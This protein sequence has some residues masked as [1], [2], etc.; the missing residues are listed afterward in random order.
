MRDVIL[1]ARWDIYTENHED[2]GSDSRQLGPALVATV[3]RLIAAGARPWIMLEVPV[4][5]FD[6]PRA[7]SRPIYSRAYIDSLCAKPAAQDE[8]TKNALTTIAKIE[9][10]G[11]RVLDPKPRF[12]DA[13]GQHYIIEAD[14]F[15]LYRDEHH[16]SKKGAEMMLLPFFREK[17]ALGK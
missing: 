7:L 3:R 14:G 12:L 4:Q 16:L 2:D 15:S 6:V 8:L 5:N 13:T 10:V 1:I 9:A 11:G 17:L